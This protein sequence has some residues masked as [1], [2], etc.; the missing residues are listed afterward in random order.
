MLQVGVIGCGNAG[1]QT[2][3]A[4]YAKY[5][6]I[7]VLAINCSEKDL[8]TVDKNILQKVV[9]DGKGAGKNRTESKKFM[10]QR[11]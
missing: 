6:D 4:S 11:V 2:V 8:S 7:P 3:S 5:K 1:N 9:G 10:A